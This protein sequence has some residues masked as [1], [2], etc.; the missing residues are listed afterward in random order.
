MYA[1]IFHTWTILGTVTPHFLDPG[2]SYPISNFVPQN[3]WCW[4]EVAVKLL[5]KLY[6]KSPKMRVVLEDD[7]ASFW[8]VC[9]IFSGAFAGSLWEGSTHF[10]FNIPKK[11]VPYRQKFG[12]LS[13]QHCCITFLQKT[14]QNSPCIA[15]PRVTQSLQV[16]SWFDLSIRIGSTLDRRWIEMSEL[17]YL[18]LWSTSFWKNIPSETNQQSRKTHIMATIAWWCLMAIQQVSNKWNYASASIDTL[19]FHQFCHMKNWFAGEQS[20]RLFRRPASKAAGFFS[21]SFTAKRMGTTKDNYCHVN[22]KPSF[23]G[24]MTP[25]VEGPKPSFFMVLGSKGS[26]LLE[27]VWSIFVNMGIFPK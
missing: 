17:R 7:P 9:A 12:V 3:C 26:W 20:K 16:G 23:L 13:H 18:F 11:V 6:S 24:V 25:F 1:Y 8:G 10:S 21:R 19:D 22:R 14:R 15:E 5:Q 2:P 27:P 4:N